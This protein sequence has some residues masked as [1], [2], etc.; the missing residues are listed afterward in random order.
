M[1]GKERDEIRALLASK[2]RPVGWAERWA[3]IDEVG[4]AWPTAPEHPYP[5]ASEDAMA[6]WR[7]LRMRGAAAE[8][9]AAGDDSAGDDLT[10]VLINRLLAAA[11]LT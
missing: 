9:I 1:D 10:I 11:P 4:A 7:S 2:P 5:A 3:R 6:A 8:H